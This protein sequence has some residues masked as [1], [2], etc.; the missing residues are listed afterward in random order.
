MNATIV[1]ISHRNLSCFQASSRISSFDQNPANGKM[2]D[3]EIEPIRN[4]Q[5]V[6]G[7]TRLFQDS[8]DAQNAQTHEHPF[9][10][11]EHG[12]GYHQTNFGK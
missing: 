6:H 11:K 4:V 12:R 2:P 5:N 1:P 3:R 8:G 7:M 9:V 10:Q